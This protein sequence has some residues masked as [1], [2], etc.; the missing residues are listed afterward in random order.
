[1]DFFGN[2]KSPFGYENGT[3]GAMTAAL[4]KNNY[5][6]GRDVTR[7]LQNELKER[8]P[9]LYGGAEFLGAVQSPAHLFRGATKL[10]NAINATTDTLAA[11]AGYAENWKD[12]GIN[13]PVYGVANVA[14]LIADKMPLGRAAG[15]PLVQFGKK[16]VKQRINSSADKIKNMFY[17]DRE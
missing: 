14:G 5:E 1:M 8:H 7:Q 15:N 3:N 11:S 6:L 17:D 13:L 12:F 16:I 9:Y 10:K 2:Y 4:S